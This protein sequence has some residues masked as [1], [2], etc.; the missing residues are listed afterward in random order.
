MYFTHPIRMYHLMYRKRLNS[1]IFFERDEKC[2]YIHSYH[3]TRTRR[4]Q[5]N[6]IFMKLDCQDVRCLQHVV[7]E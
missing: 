3:M 4:L 5:Y 7:S 2:I 1:K 6:R